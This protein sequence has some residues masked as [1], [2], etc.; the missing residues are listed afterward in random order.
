MLAPLALISTLSAQKLP[1]PSSPPTI[2][3][4]RPAI[5]DSSVVVPR[6][7]FVFENGLTETNASGQHIVDLP[8]TLVR[9]GLT[10]KTELRFNAP[11][12]L[13][14][15]SSGAVSGWGDLSFGLKQQLFATSRGFDASFVFGLSCPTGSDAVSSH[16]YDPQLLAPISYALSKNWT[17]AGM[18][19]LLL[20]TQAGRHNPTGQ[21]SFYVDRQL[22]RR[23]EAFLEYGGDYPE[24]GG[25]QHVLHLGGSFKL[26]P[27]QQLDMHA[28]FGLS[29]AA[30][31]SYIGLGY[32][33]QFRATSP[34]PTSQP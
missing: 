26:T 23:W 2:T 12:Y 17:A 21:A 19:G 9:F 32:S 15:F 29:S 13:H 27:N 25:A 22:T 18:F 34:R 1:P 28:G 16:G 14:N 10:S 11:D 5:T 4:D 24:R 6:H 3:T 8:A 33:F 20:P 30:P 31:D 7:E